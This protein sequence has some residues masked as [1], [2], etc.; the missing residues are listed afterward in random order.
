MSRLIQ[1]S[2]RVL[3]LAKRQSA[4]K[5]QISRDTAAR[6]MVVKSTRKEESRARYPREIPAHKDEA[7]GGA[8]IVT[9]GVREAG[10]EN[11]R[12][13]F[14]DE[15]MKDLHREGE[16]KSWL[17]ETR[18]RAI[19]VISFLLRIYPRRNDALAFV[20]LLLVIL[21]VDSLRADHLGL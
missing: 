20:L 14:E 4:R 8:A 2:G 6:T 17:T 1:G 3:R 16:D 11:P 13:Y 12:G 5:G 19:K 15:R 7:A 10:E 18:G 21:V 9:D